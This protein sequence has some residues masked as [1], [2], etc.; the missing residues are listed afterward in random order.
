MSL[1]LYQSNQFKPTQKVT[2]YRKN[3]M[4]GNVVKTEMKLIE[5]GKAKYAQ[6]NNAPFV[7][8]IPKRKRKASLFRE[9]YNPYM[10]IVEGWDNINPNG[11][12]DEA[13]KKTT[14]SGLNEV[15]VM[16]SSYISF[17]ERYLSDFD[18][19]VDKLIESDDVKVIADFRGV[20]SY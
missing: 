10:L 17:D 12:Y 2:V 19:I 11:M 18:A 15:T 3:S 8:G 16:R 7:A 9:T 6:Y 4:F 1:E 14:G 5:F 13:S 20:D